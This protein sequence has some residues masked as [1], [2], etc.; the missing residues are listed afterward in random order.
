MSQLAS[1]PVADDGFPCSSVDGKADAGVLLDASQRM[2]D[3][4]GRPGATTAPRHGAEVETT[5]QARGAGEHERTTD[6]RTRRSGSEALT[7]L[8]TTFGQNGPTG[9]STHAQAK[10][11]RLG[12]PAV[13]GLEGALAHESS[14]IRVGR[15]TRRRKRG[16]YVHP[17]YGRTRDTAQRRCRPAADRSTLRAGATWGQTPGACGTSPRTTYRSTSPMPVHNG[18]PQVWQAVSVHSATAPGLRRGPAASART[19][20]ASDLIHSLWTRVWTS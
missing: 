18:L 7:T 17:A 14:T 2:H 3:E 12:P 16:T 15:R 5:A 19:G 20:G 11:M 10:P 4:G 8:T 9:P 13:V 1:D 6:P